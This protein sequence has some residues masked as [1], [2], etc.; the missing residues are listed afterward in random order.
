MMVQDVFETSG[1]IKL[2]FKM[3]YP[4]QVDKEISYPLVV[5]YFGGGWKTGTI[6]QFRT[7]ALELSKEGY[8]VATP[9][10]RVYEYDHTMIDTALNDA[11]F[12][13]KYITKNAAQLYVNTEEIFLSG[14]SAGGHLVLGLLLFNDF[15]CTIEPK[16]IILFNPVVDTTKQGYQSKALTLIDGE[17]ERFSPFHHLKKLPNTIIF[18]GTADTTMPYNRVKSFVEK[19]E[20]LGTKVCLKTYKGREHGFFNKNKDTIEKDYY[21]VLN[22]IQTFLKEC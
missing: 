2:P 15:Q 5:M 13:L 7:Q 21:D 3:Y 20:K 10:Y 16:G 9:Y 12:F 6:E 11:A 19:C 14:A 17:G 8:I 1:G 4:T 18:H 22:A